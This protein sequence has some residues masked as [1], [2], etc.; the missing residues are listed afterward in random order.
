MII[1]AIKYIVAINGTSFS[2]T[3]DILLMPPINTKATIIA[4]IIPE[5][6][7]GSLIV[8]FNNPAIAL[9][10]VIFPAPK[11]AMDAKIANKIESHFCLS[12]FFILFINFYRYSINEK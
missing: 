12:P 5:T 7:S 2:E 3:L 4:T 6:Y 11:V 10:C 8:C 9:D 1:D